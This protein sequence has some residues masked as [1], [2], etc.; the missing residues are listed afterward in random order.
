[1]KKRILA[2]LLSLCLSVGLFPVT[3]LA[4]EDTTPDETVTLLEGSET[5]PS[6]DW[7]TGAE[8]NVTVYTISTTAS[9]A[10]RV[11][12]TLPRTAS[13]TRPGSWAQISH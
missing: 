5:S 8:E 9:T 10:L 3:A 1:M 6:Y 12:A 4:A 2:I 11:G 13:R 7:Y